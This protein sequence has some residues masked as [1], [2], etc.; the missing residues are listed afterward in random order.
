MASACT[1]NRMS[2]ENTWTSLG[3]VFHATPSLEV[4]IASAQSLA[5]CACSQRLEWHHLRSKLT[6]QL[7]SNALGDHTVKQLSI[8]SEKR[9]EKIR[10]E[11]NAENLIEGFERYVYSFGAEVIFAIIVDR[12]LE[13]LSKSCFPPI[14]ER[15]MFATKNLFEV[16]H[17]STHE[18][19]W[20]KYFP[21]KS[22]RKLAKCE[23]IMYDVFSDLI[24][25]DLI[26]GEATETQ[27]LVLNQI[28]TAEAG[29]E[30]TGNATMFLLHDILNNPE[31]KVHVYEELDQVLLS[32]EDA[33]T[34]PI[35]LKLKC[36][37]ACITE[38]LRMTPVA[39]NVARILE[40]RLSFDVITLLLESAF[41]LL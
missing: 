33:K 12:R 24:N 22:Y 4:D 38:S 26:S 36:L 16:S 1:S 7:A 17:E 6:T 11:R 31:V 20:W 25:K 8:I 27:S 41:N 35:L 15:L 9:I 32:P 29:I 28:L 10:E 40:N 34:P 37:I 18:L 2:R 13:A 30:T 5:L 39:P 19:P 21:T 23:D 3:D 14:A